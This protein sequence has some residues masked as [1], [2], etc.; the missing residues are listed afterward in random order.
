MFFFCEHS[1]EELF[2]R[3]VFIVMNDLV[4]EKCELLCDLCNVC[5]CCI[6]LSLLHVSEVFVFWDF[7]VRKRGH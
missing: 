6:V 4:R 3:V 7:F 5:N 1:W 2:Y